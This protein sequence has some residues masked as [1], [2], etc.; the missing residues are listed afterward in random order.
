MRRLI[1]KIK[2]WLKTKQTIRKLHKAERKRLKKVK[3]ML[4]NDIIKAKVRQ[5]VYNLGTVSVQFLVE[6]MFF[7]SCICSDKEFETIITDV[8]DRYGIS[9]SW[10]DSKQS[11]K[12]YTIYLYND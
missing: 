8:R 5:S 12:H 1:F 10:N 11:P 6:G 3:Q 9:L 2:I 4:L 7:D